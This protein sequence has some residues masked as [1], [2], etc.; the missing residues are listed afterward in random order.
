MKT[1]NVEKYPSNADLICTIPFISIFLIPI[2]LAAIIAW[3]LDSFRRLVIFFG[4]AEQANAVWSIIYPYTFLR[5]KRDAALRRLLAEFINPGDLVFDVGANKGLY[6]ELFLSMEAR[7]VI[8]VEPNVKFAKKFYHPKVRYI[9]A[10]LGSHNHNAPFYI[11]EVDGLSS[12]SKEYKSLP[13]YSAFKWKEPINIFVTTLDNLMHDYGVPDFIKIDTEGYERE[14]FAGM[15]FA[16]KALLFEFIPEDIENIEKCTHKLD[17]LGSYQYT[18]TIGLEPDM[19]FEMEWN[20]ARVLID[21]IKI[22]A[23]KECFGDIW[24]KRSN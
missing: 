2:S 23:P 7:Q 15:S 19:Q 12:L 3:F 13:R 17:T 4:I 5:R 16:P 20:T 14:V 22:K 21:R 11:G 24:V 6:T 8:A 18:Y 10:A 9:S 1:L